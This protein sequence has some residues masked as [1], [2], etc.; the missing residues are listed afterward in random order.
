M[1]TWSLPACG[2]ALPF[3][4]L[5]GSA[6]WSRTKPQTLKL[7]APW[8]WQGRCLAGP[9]LPEADPPALWDLNGV[10]ENGVLG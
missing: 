10:H 5:G 1:G 4:S 6:P 8:G 2:R 9:G 3:S 7:C